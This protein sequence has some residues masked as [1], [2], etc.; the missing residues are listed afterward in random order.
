MSWFLFRVTN[1]E[2]GFY[3][4]GEGRSVCPHTLIAGVLLV[5]T[6]WSIATQFLPC[7]L[8]AVQLCA[9]EAHLRPAG[10]VRSH[11]VSLTWKIKWRVDWFASGLALMYCYCYLHKAVQPLTEGLLL[12]FFSNIMPAF[13]QSYI[14]IFLLMLFVLK[15]HLKYCLVDFPS[16]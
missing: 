5:F 10:G 3:H 16:L 7:Y 6:S 9:V 1:I 2:N 11:A 13:L 12:L 4:S 8:F 14:D 15:A